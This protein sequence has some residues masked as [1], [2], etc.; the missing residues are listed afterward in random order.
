MTTNNADNISQAGVVFSDGAG[1]FTGVSQSSPELL[2]GSTGNEPKKVEPFLYQ[3]NNCWFWNL[4]F[5]HAAGTLTIAG[6]DGTALSTSN[7]ACITMPSNVTTGVLKNFILTA[8]QTLTVSDLDGNLGY[9]L[10]GE[11]ISNPIPLYIGFMA[12]SSDTNLTGV[13]TWLPSVKAAPSSSTD[14]GD[15]SAANADEQFSVF[16]FDDITEANYTTS[17]VGLIGSLTATKDASDQYTLQ[18]L[19]GV[20][21]GVGKWNN[22]K[23]F[24][25]AAGQYGS[26]SGSFMTSTSTPPTFAST[27]VGYFFERNGTFR[28]YSRMD[29]DGG[30]DGSGGNFC[31]LVSP[32]DLYNNDKILVG[33]GRFRA[34]SASSN[35]GLCTTQTSATANNFVH[36][37]DK[38]AN[39]G[40]LICSD[41]SAGARA[42]SLCFEYLPQV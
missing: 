7:P 20:H 35:I 38:S 17:S 5:T 28:M 36:K 10:T 32:I 15:P 34:Q 26:S 22:R 6:A 37:S 29:G 8:N 12:D 24:T 18:S 23:V 30:A 40:N 9:T 11:N 31:N 33:N 3:G 13:V 2:F 41:Y 16:A 39:F 25:F 4:S 19:D 14:I 1:T 27:S 42:C 21:D